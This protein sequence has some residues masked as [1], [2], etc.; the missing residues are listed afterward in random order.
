VCGL[1][2]ISEVGIQTDAQSL[3]RI[4]NRGRRI[5]RIRRVR[6]KFNRWQAYSLDRKMWTESDN[7]W[8]FADLYRVS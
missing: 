2:P 8:L 7:V 3:V 1:K 5:A 6:I 4:V